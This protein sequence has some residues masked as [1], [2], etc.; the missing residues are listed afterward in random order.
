MGTKWT[1]TTA[2]KMCPCCGER[3]RW[4]ESST[5]N[6]G[7]SAGK[8]ALGAVALGPLGLA[9]GALGK[10]K[11]VYYCGNCGYS[12]SYDNDMYLNH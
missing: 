3:V 9:A 5:R 4:M 10:K 7:F 11:H 6:E 12:A 2:P 1:G 8:A